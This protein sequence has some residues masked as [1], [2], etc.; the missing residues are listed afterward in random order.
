MWPPDRRWLL[1]AL[2]LTACGPNM[3]DQPRFDPY[4]AS[5]F[6]ADGTSARSPVEGTVPRG[7]LE[8]DEHFYRG[9]VDGRPARELPVALDRELLERGRQRYEIFC[10][11]CHG[12]L[13]V[14]DGMIVQRGFSPPPS[15]HSDRLRGAPVGHVFQVISRGLGRMPAYGDRVPTADRWAIV[16]YVRVLQLS[17][18]AP[19]ELVPEEERRRLEEER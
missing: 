15:F 8:A 2:L 17:Q 18:R 19:L 12:A 1:A 7:R 6:F 5:G 10:T 11:P 13:G 16:A 14:G 9:T 3:R 4:Q